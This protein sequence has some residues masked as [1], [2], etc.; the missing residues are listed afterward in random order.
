[1]FSHRDVTT[2]AQKYKNLSIKYDDTKSES[3][4]RKNAEIESAVFVKGVEEHTATTS[5]ISFDSYVEYALK[6][7]EQAGVT[8]ATIRSYKTFK[9]KLA[10]YIGHVRLK[11]LLP[12]ALNKYYSDMIEAGVAKGYVY[13]LHRFVHNILEMAFKECL[14][15]RNYAKAAT[16][17]KKERKKMTAMSEEQL[18]AFF[19]ALYSDERNYERQVLF[20]LLLASGCRIGEL[21]ATSFND[22]DFKE[23]S[24]LIRRHWVH[25]ETGQYVTDGCKTTAGERL[26]YF[27]KPIMKMLFDYR[28]YHYKKAQEYGTK[29]DFT[30]NAI[31]TSVQSPGDYLNP[32]TVRMW[33]TSF[34]KKNNLPDMSPHKFRHTSISLQLQAGISVPDVSKR[35]GHA[36]PD[37]TL[38]FYAHTI[39]NNDRHC[40]EAVTKVLPKL[41]KVMTS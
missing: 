4:N 20:S 30:T 11:D 6:I 10:P 37:V 13:E 34:L 2:G 40:S 41:P 8:N 5:T 19:S 31:F 39:K 36:R 28:S 12:N 22:V 33:L 26:L 35:A 27:D 25:D 7:K 18:N 24:I 14:V 17:P 29:W 1:V 23:G 21:C 15:P 9:K 38:L 16:P 3:W 32:N